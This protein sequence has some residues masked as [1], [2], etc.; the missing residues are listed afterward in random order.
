ME[1]YKIG[2]KVEFYDIYGQLRRVKVTK[3][4]EEIATENSYSYPGFFGYYCQGWAKIVIWGWDYKITR[5][6]CRDTDK[7][8]KI[9]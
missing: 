1:I 9:K 3:K 6:F 5:V 2:D 7:W 4:H 8:V